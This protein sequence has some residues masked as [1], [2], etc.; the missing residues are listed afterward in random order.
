MAIQIET[1]VLGPLETNA[2]VLRE[3]GA[4]WVID[5][6]FY[7]QNL[8]RRLAAEK[9]GLERILLTHAH[10]DH[11]AGVAQ[12]KQAFPRAVLC[13]P[14]GDAAMLTSPQANLSAMMGLPISCPPADQVVHPGDV[15]TF[16]SSAW[17]VLDVSGHS[18]GGAAYY[19][20]E[21]GVVIAGDSLFAG[22]GVGRTDF[23]GGSILRLL[24][25]IRANLMTLPPRTRVLSGHGPETTIGEEAQYNAFRAD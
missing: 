16:A 6:S 25:N 5:P 15:L 24:E 3:G 13:C 4:C 10:G 2:Y 19:C 9:L 11:I 12:L 21:L 17:K 18:P 22:G 20:A 14:A 23:P 7:P 1:F 8:L